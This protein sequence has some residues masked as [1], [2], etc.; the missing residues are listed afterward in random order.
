[1]FIKN[2]VPE[3][4]Y[5]FVALEDGRIGFLHISDIM[6]SFKR[7]E[8]LTG[9][10]IKDARIEDT[11][12]GS[13]LKRVQLIMT[14]GAN[15][16][17]YCQD[18][19]IFFPMYGSIISKKKSVYYF[20]SKTVSGKPVWLHDYDPIF[21]ILPE[22]I[23]SK[24]KESF[25]QEE[26]KYNKKASH[27]KAITEAWE[28]AGKIQVASGIPIL[29]ATEKTYSR[30]SKETWNLVREEWDQFIASLELAG[31]NSAYSWY[32]APEIS[33]KVIKVTRGEEEVEISFW[34][35]SRK[36]DCPYTP[37]IWEKA[38]KKTA[39]DTGDGYG[40]GFEDHSERFG[41]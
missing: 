4:G 33:S 35:V 39:I 9:L 23:L 28:E 27:E 11:P 36:K 14:G 10:E 18:A 3:K 7:G 29:L 6:E 16:E 26:E 38:P 1:M 24:M 2:W 25:L 12:K 19:V 34:K 30:V 41:W 40:W 8:D 17:I 20:R 32:Y 15:P 21:N 37:K 22:S 5:G 13:V 31:S